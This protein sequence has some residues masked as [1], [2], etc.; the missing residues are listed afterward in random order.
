MVDYVDILKYVESNVLKNTTPFKHTQCEGR[1]F[2]FQK[3]ILNILLQV[4]KTFE[5]V[6]N[7]WKKKVSYL[8]K[9]NFPFQKINQ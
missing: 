4:F 6:K 1:F 2:L 7:Q 5:G 8:D 9:G 3:I